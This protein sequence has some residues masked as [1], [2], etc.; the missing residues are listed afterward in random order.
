M[1]NHKKR[2][3]TKN[4]KHKESLDDVYAVALFALS[5][6]LIIS[7]F[8]GDRGLI[9]KY[10][11]RVLEYSVGVGRYI[12]PVFLVGWG[13]SFLIKKIRLNVE[14]TGLGL[15]VSFVSII[16]L[17]HLSVPS[18]KELS[19]EYIV[20][21]GG[22]I[23]GIF[24][25]VLRVLLGNVGSYIVL[26]ALLII[27]V[28]IFTGISLSRQFS[29]LVN[30]VKAI[31]KPKLKGKKESI[32]DEE[33][34]TRGFSKKEKPVFPEQL[35][36]GNKENAR[37]TKVIPAETNEFASQKTTE[38]KIELP[39]LKLGEY[40]F[41]PPS[42]LKKTLTKDLHLK[43]NIKEN[44]RVLERTLANFDVDARINKV[45]KGP[46]VTLYEIQLASGV[47][48]NRILGLADDI[49]LALASSDIRILAPIPGKS[50]I[51]I[52]VPN[53]QR[54][55]VT[56]GDILSNPEAQ[57]DGILKVAL[58]KDIS[59]K[60]VIADIGDMPHLLI[61]GSTGSGKSVC[62]NSILMSLLMRARPDQVKMI[63]IDP[64]RIELTFYDGIPH[65]VTP[66]VVNPKEASRALLWAVKEM[67]NRLGLLAESGT[68]NIDGYNAFL[69]KKEIKDEF[70]PYIVIVIDEL[71]DLMMV[72][73]GEVEGS[74]CRLAQL[75]RAVGIH[76]VIATQRPS[77]NVIT[78]LIK[79][80]ITSRVAFAV[81]SQ[82]DSRVILDS[83][84]AEK[85]VGKGDM[86]FMTPK[87]Q[88][89]KRL[90]C[91]F[92]SEQEVELVTDF[93][94]KQAKP[95]YQ[96]EILEKKKSKFS[97]DDY[98]DDLFDDAMELVVSIGMASVSMLQRR[99]RIGYTRAARLMDILEERGIV[100]PSEGSKSRAV[101]L[102]K[103]DLE[104][105][106]KG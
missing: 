43:K 9:G 53:K 87:L 65:L 79:A 35:I 14:S 95:S 82:I 85:L 51:G 11:V 36:Q 2:V 5:A 37:K 4:K 103:E 30:G 29:V 46:T 77:V 96:G 66:V 6:I 81:S 98:E 105:M 76:L 19:S 69:R 7:L 15:A 49:A 8:A 61:A 57:R 10:I 102:T 28:V 22:Y 17:I 84:G 52:E 89:L 94:K 27:G 44:V 80:N 64:K 40:Q 18:S 71:A 63:L 23:G 25:Y 60:P 24:A 90:Q 97:L 42:L 56:L 99:L 1:A 91:S 26:F 3:F 34:I 13:I 86:L 16:S 72:A 67:E 92:V 12:I 62:I 41:P 74:I 106:R 32:F 93:V 68:R 47:K 73:P 54:E 20:S 21:Y 55:L 48:V 50:A 104:K 45:T 75:A 100:G 101:F 70:M 31:F 78:G 33:Q 38:L 58:G 59:G 39:K 83:A 88:K